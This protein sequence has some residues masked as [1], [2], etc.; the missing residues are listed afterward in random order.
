M[1]VERLLLVAIVWI[2]VGAPAYSQVTP[3]AGPAETPITLE[4]LE[5]IAL[6]NNPTV[7]Q[8][9]TTIEAARGRARQAGAWPNPTIGIA[10]EEVSFG[11]TIR[12][13]E[14]GVFATQTIP[15][16]GK[17]R[18]GRAVFESE[19]TQAQSLADLQQQR[20]LS[21]VRT[22]YY[23]VLTIE[24]RVDV[25][26]RL[27][28]LSNEAVG[29]TRQ[30]YNVGAA[31]R[32]DVL[33][34]EIEAQR[35]QLDLTAARNSRFASWRRLAA[36]VGDRTLM[37]RPLATSIDAAIPELDRDTTLRRILDQSPEVRAAR[38][39]IERNRAIVSRARRETFPDLF[40]RGGLAYNRELLETSAA[41]R[42]QAV[43]REGSFEVGLS[44]PLFNRNQGGV[45][46]ALAEESRAEVEMMRL[47]LSIESRLASAFDAYLTALRA[48]EAYRN[49]MLPRAEEAYRLYLARYREAA[50]AYP[51]VL[52]A[53]RTLFQL[54]AEYLEDLEVAWRSALR[55]QGFLVEDDGLAPPMRAGEMPIG[56]AGG[57]VAEDMSGR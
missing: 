19:A 40:L 15:L 28:Q 3:P 47:Q 21:A 37:P 26:D 31:D 18:L 11:P 51:Q 41:G 34:A 9:S 43:G 44:V 10:G 23:E 12:G 56:T 46:A 2:G 7:R 8:A 4:Q 25:L 53:Q 1:R 6:L 22:Q 42:P 54:N 45:A 17:L 52:I 36:T 49:D 13:G 30:L 20:I 27:T 29:V 38:A 50:A 55:I 57:P 14:Y 39:D 33:E 16:G 48:A 5:R 24:R 32:P 35:A